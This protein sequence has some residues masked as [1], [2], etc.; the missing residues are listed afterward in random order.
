M[1]GI[2]ARPRSRKAPQATR[3]SYTIMFT[4]ALVAR[5]SAIAG[6]CGVALLAAAPAPSALGIHAD[7]VD[8]ALD[9]GHSSW[10]VGATSGGLRE[11]ELTLDV[12]RRAQA[13]IEA[14]GHTVRLTRDGTQRVA[15]ALPSDLT[16]AVE[17]EQRAR[18]TASAPAHIYVSIHFN[19]HPDA[20]L[21]GTETYYNSENFGDASLR[22]A[23]LLHD[24]TLGAI[25]E[26][27]ASARDRGVKEDLLAGKPYGHFF[28]LRGPFPSALVEVLFLSNPLD[29][30]LAGDEA[31]RDRVADG[32]SRGIARYLAEEE[33]S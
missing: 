14:A 7:L 3:V 1:E 18:H 20:S 25:R 16:C 4:M 31:V 10:D 2:V 24:E 32:V 9:P 29:A 21:R 12:A 27:D 33:R 5:L 28:S 22:L 15:A 30:T 26:I 19:G 8:V 6:V 13:R 23:R 17:S 11:F